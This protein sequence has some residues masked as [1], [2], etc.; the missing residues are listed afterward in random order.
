ML[1]W[2][3]RVRSWIPDFPTKP[4]AEYFLYLVAAPILV[5]WLA[6]MLLN[7]RERHA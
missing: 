2:F 6:A 5:V 1:Q 3:V 7:H 4:V